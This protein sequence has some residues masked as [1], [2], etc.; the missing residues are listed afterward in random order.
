MNANICNDRNIEVAAAEPDRRVWLVAILLIVCSLVVFGQTIGFDFLMW[1]DE[2]F[3]LPYLQRFHGLSADS[4]AWAFTNSE[5]GWRTPIPYLVFF[6]EMEIFG[7]NPGGYHFTSLLIHTFST[8]LLFAA[9]WRMT[10]ELW[11][12]GTVAVLFAIHPLHVEPVAWITGRWDLLCGFFWIVGLWAYVGYC[13]RPGVYRYCVVALAYVCAIMSK[14]MALT[15]P[16]AL[17]LLDVWPLGRLW[18]RAETAAATSEVDST[19][20][21]P[22]PSWRFVIL[23]K[24]P[25]FAI[26]I[27]AFLITFPAKRAYFASR[28]MVPIEFSDRALN[29]VEAYADYVLQFVWPANLSFYY[30][31]PAITGGFSAISLAIAVVLLAVVTLT[32]AWFGRRRG[33]LI[34]GWLWF[35]GV[36]VPTIGLF[37]VE[38]HARADRYLYIPLIGLCLMAV[39]GIRDLASRFRLPAKALVAVSAVVVVALIPAARFQTSTWKNSWSLFGY[40]LSLDETNHKA[41]TG[42]GALAMRENKLQLAEHYFRRNLNAI[43]ERGKHYYLLGKCLYLQNRNEEALRYLKT[44]V[45][46][47]PGMTNAR[48]M[49]AMALDKSGDREAA[50]VESRKMILARPDDPLAYKWLADF[51]AETGNYEEAVPNYLKCLE[52]DPANQRVP[53]SLATVYLLQGRAEAAVEFYSA[54]LDRFPWRADVAEHL[55]TILAAHPEAAPAKVSKSAA[56]TTS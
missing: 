35:L 12:S 11:A 25:L 18:E 22:Q 30:Q 42:L 6:T 16:C 45:R 55:A 9:L 29:T 3:V 20:G 34:T 51:C 31:H 33:Y 14:P 4:V 44:S 24:V 28:Q 37:Q 17:L 19:R 47:T 32:V 36:L 27:V 38:Y 46:T 7:L 49:L 1:D 2:P 50:L 56:E 26:M 54:Y 10:G 52:M 43:P 40:G 39:W 8:L 5:N 48:R 15:F 41:L 21:R 53:K 23:E 13:R